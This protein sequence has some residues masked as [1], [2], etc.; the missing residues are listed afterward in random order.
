MLDNFFK[1][2]G[3]FESVA[4][5]WLGYEAIKH[6]QDASG[7]GQQEVYNKPTTNNQVNDVP[8]VDTPKGLST[9]LKIG[10]GAVGLLG[11]VLLIRK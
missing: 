1:E 4:G 10:L 8:N 9:E 11:L 2:G 5:T 7:Q 6:G 3:A